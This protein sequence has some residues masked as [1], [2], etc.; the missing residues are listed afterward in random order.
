M[1]LCLSGQLRVMVRSGLHHRLQ[2]LLV[3]PLGA[4]VFI[5]VDAADTRQWGVTKA[6]PLSDYEEVV[7]VMRPLVTSHASYVPPTSPLAQCVSSG[8]AAAPADHMRVCAARD[9]GSFSCGCYVPGC[10]MCAVGQYIPQHA[11]TKRCLEMIQRHE[12]RRGR[13]YEVVIK[14]RPD[15]NVTRQV[16]SYDEILAALAGGGSGGGVPAHAIVESQ[17]LPP[18]L[19]AQGG[20][21]PPGEPEPLAS[22]PLTLDDKFGLMTREVAA[23]Y[24]NATG[25][26][27]ACQSRRLN[28]PSCGDGGLLQ[29]RGGDA[30]AANLV[31][32]RPGGGSLKAKLSSSRHGLK[33]ALAG[34]H[35]AAHQP[36][37]AT[38]QCVLKRHLLTHL[39]DVRM[40]DCLREPGQRPLLR[41]VRPM[42]R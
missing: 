30:A 9:C 12:V 19:C 39:P 2:R 35:F 28:A 7:R 32:A 42:A 26:F 17:G 36:Y 21:A 27:S 8:A 25:A 3:Q 29:A 14:T 34:A 20:G 16:R 10:S 37:W 15:L 23:V 41:L 40:V 33:R 13:R 31:R 22:L 1:A 38:P 11:H 5:H 4:D 24:M 6:A 18:T